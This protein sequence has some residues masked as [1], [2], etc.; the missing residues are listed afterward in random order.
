MLNNVL[1]DTIQNSLSIF[2]SGINVED[3]RRVPLATELLNNKIAMT[4]EFEKVSREEAIVMVKKSHDE[5]F[6]ELFDYLYEEPEPG[7][8]EYIMNNKEEAI[9]LIKSQVETIDFDCLQHD[10]GEKSDE[11]FLVDIHFKIWNLSKFTQVLR[12]N[13]VI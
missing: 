6:P 8:Y 10:I 3:A 9:Q 1:N 2:L 7:S 13:N 11:D 12:K 5:S 4:Q